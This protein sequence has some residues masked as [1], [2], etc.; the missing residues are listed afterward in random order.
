MNEQY[1]NECIDNKKWD[2][3]RRCVH[4]LDFVPQYILNNNFTRFNGMIIFFCISYNHGIH[5]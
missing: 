4:Y 3:A 5:H 1:F 2:I